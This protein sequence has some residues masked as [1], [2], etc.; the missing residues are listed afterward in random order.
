M[1]FS[2]KPLRTL[3][4]GAVTASL[5]LLSS[6]SPSEE[7]P[8]ESGSPSVSPSPTITIEPSADL[9]GIQ[10]SDEDIPTVT[11]EA[12]WAIEST[13]SQVLREG[14]PQLLQDDSVITIRFAGYNGRTGEQFD[15][16]YGEGQPVTYPLGGFVPGFTTSLVG[17]AVGSRVLV[18]IVS[19]DGYAAGRPEAGI[20]PGDSLVFVI[21]ILS[22]N[23]SDAT[24]EPV[25]PVEGLPAVTMTDDGPE[26][27]IP[28]GS[29]PPEQLQTATLIQGPGEAITAESLVQVRFRSWVY[30]DGALLD[31]GW[32]QPQTGALS[33]LIDGWVQGLSGQTAGSR[34]L[35][36]VPPA[37]AY[38]TGRPTPEP[39]LPAGQTLVYVIDVLDVQNNPPA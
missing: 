37:L 4:I 17:K 31:D 35:L 3:V 6:C 11:F 26:V 14:G 39:G 20:E 25:P 34:V 1:V 10:V 23:F 15:G 27:A 8:S 18:G 7:Q 19:E 29:A 36:V 24:G 13:Q 30:A 9:S 28:A 12:P 38:P 22:A 5:L 33:E 2:L 32:S 16:N 21:D